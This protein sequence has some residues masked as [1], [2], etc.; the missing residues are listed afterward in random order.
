MI[1][2]RICSPVPGFTMMRNGAFGAGIYGAC[3]RGLDRRFMVTLHNRQIG[4]MG[5]EPAANTLA[6]MNAAQMKRNGKALDAAVHE[7]PHQTTGKARM[8][9]LSTCYAASNTRDDGIGD[10]ADTRNALGMAI[11]SALAPPLGAPCHGALSP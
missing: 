9:H 5:G 6:D 1:M 7:D 8:E 10:P 2:M 4:L 3:G 11:T